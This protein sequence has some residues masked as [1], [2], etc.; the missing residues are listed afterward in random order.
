MPGANKLDEVDQSGTPGIV[1]VDRPVRPSAWARKDQ[2]QMVQRGGHL[3]ALYPHTERRADLTPIYE[4]TAGDV[5]A[6]NA[7][8]AAA[9]WA[10]R[11]LSR[12]R[13]DHN[14]W[15]EHCFPPEFRPGG[16]WDGA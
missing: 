5:A 15:C 13:C 2:L 11:D 6:L 3:C 7:S 8:R 4:L 10:Q 14:E 9:A 12:C 16:V 1:R